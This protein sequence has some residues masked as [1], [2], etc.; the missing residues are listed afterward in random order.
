MG[1][2]ARIR[3][4]PE[5]LAVGIA[6]LAPDGT[7]QDENATWRTLAR[8]DDGGFDAAATPNFFQACTSDQARHLH[9]VVEGRSRL[10]TCL[11]AGCSADGPT[12]LVALPRRPEPP[13]P[14][15]LLQVAM[16]GLLPIDPTRDMAPEASFAD[17][18][19]F[20]IDLIVRTIEQTMQNV[21]ASGAVRP[22]WL[23]SSSAGATERDAVA[24]IL[25]MLS[26]RQREV[27][28][29]VGVGKTNA[30]IATLLGISMNTAKLHV[31]A[32]LRRLDLDNRM[33]AI[34]L[35][36]RIADRGF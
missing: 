32:I 16:A 21:M 31:S 4:T 35:G 26:P 29:L 1:G 33:Q 28:R 7:I 8:H 24:Q 10:F 36:A 6:L 27:L 11:Q 5:T 23:D 13:S 25:Q 22:H 20:G 18:P 12:L 17:E 2:L 9:D 19:T 30:E 3:S 34:A 15:I 14:L